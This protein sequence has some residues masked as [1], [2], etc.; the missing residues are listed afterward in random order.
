MKSFVLAFL[1]SFGFIL[2]SCS[3]D[4]AP[5]N[6]TTD[7][8]VDT[9]QSVPPDTAAHKQPAEKAVDGSILPEVKN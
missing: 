9:V 1:L 6:N 3:N 5:V 7:A 4:P 8:V 2:A